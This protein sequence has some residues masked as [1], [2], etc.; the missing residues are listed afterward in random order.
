[1]EHRPESH[2]KYLEQKGWTP[3][4]FTAKASAIGEFTEKVICNML[5]SKTFI[6]QTYDGCLGILRL[7][8][9]YG[10]QRLEA[11][12]K[13]AMQGSRVSYRIGW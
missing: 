8:D 4:D 1:M 3:D 9:K 5:A 11:A 12:C 13:R 10:K 7:G 2:Q 6:E